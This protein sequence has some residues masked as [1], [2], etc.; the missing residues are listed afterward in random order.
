MAFPMLLG[1]VYMLDDLSEFHLPLR[2][3]YADSLR[4]G[5]NFLWTPHI[6]NGFYLHG[7][8][9]LGMCHPVH[10]ALYRFLPLW[11]AFDLELLLNYIVMLPGTFLLLRRW[12]LRRDAAMLGGLVFTF[13]GFNLLH[14]MHL[15][16]VAVM[17][18]VP[19]LLLAIDTALRSPSARSQGRARL[20]VSLLTASELLLG[21]P[22]AVWYSCLIEGLYVLY[23]WP[24]WRADRRRLWTLGLAK[25]LGL[26]LA[27]IQLIP[28]LEAH[29]TSSRATP[30]IAFRY[31][32]SLHP[33][34]FIQLVAPYL[35]GKRVFNSNTHEVG[36]YIGAAGPLM[37]LWVGLRLRR[38]GRMRIV[39][40]AGMVT[41]GLGLLLALG[42]YSFLY[43][44]LARVPLLNGFRAPCRYLL[45]FHL[46]AALLMAVAFVD[47]RRMTRRGERVAWRRIGPLLLVP[48]A[49]LLCALPGV[50]A[51]ARGD[52]WLGAPFHQQAGTLG[53]VLAGPA[54]VLAATGLVVAALR[55][56]RLALPLLVLFIA[57]DLGV[58]GITYMWKRPP[59][60]IASL[61]ELAPMPPDWG[62]HQSQYRVLSWN[63][64]LLFR[65]VRLSGGYVGMT[66]CHMVDVLS[67]G[68]LRSGGTRWI[69]AAYHLP[70][71]AFEKRF[72]L[73]DYG[74]AVPD[75]LPRVRM[76]SQAMYSRFPNR[77][78]DTLDID[79]I[80]LVSD[81]ITL[82]EGPPGQARLLVDR[83]GKIGV[84]T[85]AETEQ[86]LFVNESYHNG[87]QARVDGRPAEVLRGNGDFICCVVPAGRHEVEF[88]FWPRSFRFGL[89]LTL[90]AAV[91]VLIQYVV[92]VRR[93]A[94]ASD[95]GK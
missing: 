13:S 32:H 54:L 86:V 18:H 89:F 75:P 48:L 78:I 17:A 29:T 95:P 41:G 72:E 61:A 74:W 90:L 19:W 68:R 51:W 1:Q 63:N 44:L 8:G 77:D 14:H 93:G 23:L 5:D 24:L 66:P 42:R 49:A 58:Y 81:V 84:S 12:N 39:A 91:L 76:L 64:R 4:Q 33:W 88:T 25:G 59:D 6:L 36:L 26:L 46:A 85:E 9:Q 73:H 53:Q 71:E 57:A 94:H 80:A 31:M 47:V 7:E 62:P 37:L 28:T 60:N 35:A 55:A 50:V 22:Q 82:P 83:P 3:F 65:G 34:N 11:V 52:G 70:R 45:L 43:P 87:W 56:W 2:E 20:A 40:M 10:L 69:V 15:N 21:H 79:T 30:T 16:I 92:T 27:A 38:L 67:T